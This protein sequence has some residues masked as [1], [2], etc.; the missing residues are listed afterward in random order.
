[1]GLS[2]GPDVVWTKPGEL[3]VVVVDRDSVPVRGVTVTLHPAAQKPAVTDGRG[4]VEF[5]GLPGGEYSLIFEL[6][7]FARTTLGP[8]KMRRLQDENP[9]LPEFVVIMNPV[10]WVN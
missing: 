6:S 2:R 1:M 9:H 3:R 4:R 7:G 10:M 8:V 5:T